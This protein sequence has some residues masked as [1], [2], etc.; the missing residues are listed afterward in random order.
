MATFFDLFKEEVEGH[1]GE[2]VLVLRTS[3]E[4]ASCH[5]THGTYREVT[6]LQ[7]GVLKSDAMTERK[8]RSIAFI[9]D[10]SSYASRQHNN[11]GWKLEEKPLAIDWYYFG[12]S[13]LQVGKE[14]IEDY[15]RVHGKLPVD[16]FTLCQSSGYHSHLDISY[17]RAMDLL[18]AGEM[19][20]PEFRGAYK[21]TGEIV[22]EQSVRKI[23]S[24]LE[25]QIKERREIKSVESASKG[26]DDAADIIGGDVGVVLLTVG[27]RD[28]I[29]NAQYEIINL[30]SIVKDLGFNEF[31][32]KLTRVPMNS[33]DYFSA[34]FKEFRIK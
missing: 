27:N 2:P 4:L 22:L 9:F 31:D 32:Q 12:G 5:F 20:S 18:G 7:L 6:D 30:L 29:D 25:S 10:T 1:G 28:R 24:L 16:I 14:K 17:V 34:R 8:G 11:Y 15:F 13:A 3:Q 21:K 19:V 33:R 26:H 23:E